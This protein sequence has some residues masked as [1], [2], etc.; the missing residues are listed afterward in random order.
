MMVYPKSLLSSDG[1]LLGGSKS[2]S[3]AVSKLLKYTGYEPSDKPPA[4]LDSVVID[5]MI[6]L[7]HMAT[8]RFK[9][10]KDLV[11]EFGRRIEII[12]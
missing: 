8:K 6:V 7:N 12:F 2:K 3:E 1:S 4:N 10:V 11:N 5:A 9:T